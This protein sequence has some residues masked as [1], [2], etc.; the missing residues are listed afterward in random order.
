MDATAR[1][2]APPAPHRFPLL[3]V[4][5]TSLGFAIVQLDVTIVNVA[6]PRIGADLHGGITALQWVVDA[7]TMTFAVLLL[8]AGALSDRLGARVTYAAGFSVFALASSM[9]AVAPDAQALIGARALQGIGAALLVPSSLALLDAACRHDLRIRARAVGLWTAAG[10]VSI[11]AGPIVG[12]VLVEAFG[13]RSIFVVNVPLCAAATVATLRWLSPPQSEPPARAFDPFGQLFGIVGLTAL[14]ASIIEIAGRGGHRNWI[15]GGF[16]IALASAIAFWRVENRVR[17]PMLPP[18][19]FERPGFARAL[20]FGVIVNLTYYGIVFVLALY[21]QQARGY[22]SFDAGMAF[23][24]LTA[25]FIFSNVASGALVARCG[26]RF[27]MSVGALIGAAGFALLARLD[28][29][30]GSIA[31]L[32]P[33]ALIPLGMGLGVPAMTTSVLSVIEPRWSATASGALNAARQIGG[34]LGVAA[35]GALAARGNIMGGLHAAAG[36]SAVLMIAAAA[37]AGSGT[38]QAA[39][40]FASR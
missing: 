15:V 2:P 30:S 22:A 40:R 8:S 6:L 36:V 21:L 32:V 17:A 19:F 29:A 14:V 20:L 13:W 28:A 5:A 35:F 27:P 12:G 4:A 11:A 3:P 39:T 25:T 38:R 10:G 9:C 26:P 1:F 37:I 16:V 18:A 33:F 7:Y 24:P 23:I 31:M 34:A